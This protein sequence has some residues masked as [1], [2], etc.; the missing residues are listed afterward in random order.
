MI[1]E[2]S[3]KV[4]EAIGYYVYVLVDPRTKQVFYVGKGKGNRVFDHEREAKDPQ[5]PSSDK[6]D[7]IRDIQNAGRE[8][9]KYIVRHGLDENTA[10]EVEASIIDILSYQGFN[11]SLSLTNAVSGHH[12]WDRGIKTVD[13]IEQLYAPQPAGNYMSGTRQVL[14]IT[15]NKMYPPKKH[16]PNGVYEAVRSCWKLSSRSVNNIKYVLAVY[17]G[18]V[19]G[20]FMVDSWHQIKT[21][22]DPNYAVPQDINRWC[23]YE[24]PVNKMT[25][26]EL[27]DYNNVCDSYL[28]KS[29]NIKQQNPVKYI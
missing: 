17:Q 26:N 20:V 28:N 18:V 12:Q 21:S 2:F 5:T 15:I 14:S 6:I 29:L 27:N 11:I 19:R 13:D 22:S 24:K 4:Q 16:L 23:F 8:V 3:K 1:K 25:Q 9:E 10:Y 7:Q